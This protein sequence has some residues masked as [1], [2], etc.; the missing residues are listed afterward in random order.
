MMPKTFLIL[1][2]TALLS[3]L[4]AGTVPS[5]EVPAAPKA[6]H[7]NPYT[8]TP[9]EMIGLTMA[10]YLPAVRAIDPSI[11]D[12]MAFSY[13][14]DTGRIIVSVYGDPNSTYFGARTPIER[15][16]SALD[17]FRN[18]YLP[19]LANEVRQIHHVSLDESDVAL[20]YFGRAHDLREVVRWEGDKYVVMK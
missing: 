10:Q 8:A 2:V 15:A 1:T 4:S 3:A 6:I 19:I 17:Y 20:I 9:G 12:P 7:T 14:H 16:K 11:D 5:S 13:D 18:K